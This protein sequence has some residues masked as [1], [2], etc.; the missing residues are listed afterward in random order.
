MRAAVGSRGAGGLTSELRN[1]LADGL[2]LFYY[3]F[4]PLTEAGKEIASEA[5]VLPVLVKPKR[6]PVSVKIAEVV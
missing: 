3:F 4:T 5:V 6:T 2:G 1:G